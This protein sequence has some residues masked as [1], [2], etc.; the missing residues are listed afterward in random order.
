MHFI[1]VEEVEVQLEIQNFS[2]MESDGSVTIFV[3]INQAFSQNINFVITSSDVTANGERF[4]LLLHLQ[5]S[6][7]L[8]FVDACDFVH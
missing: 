3:S 8:I 2:V 7:A 5:I 4:A 1:H 6:F